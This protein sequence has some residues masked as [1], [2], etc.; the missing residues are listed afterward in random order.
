MSQSLANFDRSLCSKPEIMSAMHSAC[1]NMK[2]CHDK[3]FLNFPCPVSD[4]NQCFNAYVHAC[5]QIDTWDDAAAVFRGLG[6]MGL[7]DLRDHDTCMNMYRSCLGSQH[8]VCGN[9]RTKATVHQGPFPTYSP[10]PAT[11]SP[12]K[13]SSNVYDYYGS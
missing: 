4:V 12:T 11:N 2:Q 6:C 10:P 13:S 1:Q 5:Q 9:V 7:P 3:D 8:P